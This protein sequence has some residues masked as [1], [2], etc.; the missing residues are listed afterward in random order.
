MATESRLLPAPGSDV[1]FGE[2]YDRGYQHYEGPRLGRKHAFRALTTY[3]MKRALG[4]K[5]SW[6]AKVVPVLHVHRGRADGGHS[7][8]ES[9][10]F[11][12]DAEVVEYWEFFGYHLY[13]SRGLRGHDRSG[14]AL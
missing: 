13:H 14:D 12:P 8:W 4:S 3:S 5:K 2:V 6:T 11:L 10:A 7:L 1:A 9:E